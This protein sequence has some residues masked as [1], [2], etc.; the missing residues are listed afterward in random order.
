MLALFQPFWVLLLHLLQLLLRL[1]F[2]AIGCFRHCKSN[3]QFIVRICNQ[4]KTETK[5][6]YFLCLCFPVLAADCIGLLTLVR[7]ML[8]SVIICLL[9]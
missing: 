6:L 8:A 2:L 5:P 1:C 9:L 4:M 3:R 7:I